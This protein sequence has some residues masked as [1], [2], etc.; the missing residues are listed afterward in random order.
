MNDV[1]TLNH[2][3]SGNIE[4]RRITISGAFLCAAGAEKLISQSAA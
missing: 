2:L 4:M 1:R 3:S